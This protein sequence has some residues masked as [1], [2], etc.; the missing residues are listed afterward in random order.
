MNADQA[1]WTRR[2]ERLAGVLTKSRLH[3]AVT[4]RADKDRTRG[5]W[6]VAFSGGADSLAL[7][8][9]LWAHWPERRQRLHAVHFNHRLR[10]AAAER[11]EEFCRKVCRALAIPLQVGRRRPNQAAASEAAAR[12]LRFRFIDRTM[13]GWRAR[14]LW[15]GHQQN[16]VAETLLMR[17]ARGS[18]AG[19]LAAPRPVQQMPGGRVHLRPLLGVKHPELTEALRAAGAPWREDAT[20]VQGEFFRNRIRREVL[21][22]WQ[23]AAGRDAIAGAARTRELL[24]EDDAALEAWVDELA[25]LGRSGTLAVA[26]LAGK[27]QAVVRR[28]LHRWLLR[29]RDAGEL[30]RQGFDALLT[31]VR[32]GHAT[33]H[34]LG[35]EGF[36]TLRAGV[37]C[38]EKCRVKRRK[39]RV[40]L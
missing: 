27:P 38:F 34:S 14:W 15:L 3:P 31:A 22:A 29:Q 37:L 1:R 6:V 4:D 7:L 2:A 19:G 20:N 36:A 40:R 39:S 24:E 25:P 11:D 17:L 30:S 28:A 18:G 10:G 16:D 21:P 9:L 12:A 5:P 33:K 13:A 35:A 32:R 23:E 8:L 26:A